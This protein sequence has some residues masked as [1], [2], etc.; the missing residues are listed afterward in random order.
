MRLANLKRVSYPSSVAEAVNILSDEKRNAEPLS[1]GISFIFASLP[2]VEELVCL[3]RL[4]LRYIENGKYGGLRI[5]AATRISELVDSRAVKGYADGMLWEAARRIG[6]TLNRNLITVGGN[7]VQPFIWSDLPTV[8]LALGAKFRIHGNK[9]RTMDAKK[10][11]A[12]VPKQILKRS[13]LVTEIVFP[14]LPKGSRTAYRKF[15]LTE[16]DYAFLKMAVLLER[17]KRLCRD[18]TIVAGGAALLPQR[19]MKA[20]KV[21]R[22]RNAS[23]ILVNEVSEVAA[24]EMKV[25]RDFRCTNEYKRELC[26]VMVRGI[27]EEIM[28]DQKVAEWKLL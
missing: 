22:G 11:F 2:A 9:I 19:I 21:L 13:E 8:A 7:L 17:G 14:P 28:L 4:P 5:G 25:A 26:R 10:F 16:N 12:R 27:L 18:I 20:E 24:E 15:S 1:G 3:S 6:S 23:Q